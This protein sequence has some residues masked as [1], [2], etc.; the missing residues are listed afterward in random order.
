MKLNAEF[1]R[2]NDFAQSRSLSEKTRATKTCVA[3][4]R[5]YEA[6]TERS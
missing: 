1:E 3:N 2:A 6:Q 5:Y 4:G